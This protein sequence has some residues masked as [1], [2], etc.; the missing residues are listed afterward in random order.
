MTEQLFF[1]LIRVAIGTQERL[2]RLPSAC[3]WGELYKMARKQS[4]V[5]VCFAAIQRLGAD[6]DDGFASIGMSEML[7]LTWMGMAAKI[8]QKNEA[9]NQQCAELQAKLSADGLCSCVLKGQGVASLYS[10]YLRGF[11]QPGD[12]DVWIKDTPEQVIK[13]AQ[14]FRIDEEPSYLHI[15]V[16]M[17]DDTPVELHWRPTLFR[18][19]FN[20]R[21]IQRWSES[22]DANSFNHIETLGFDIPSDD[23]NRIFNLTHLYRHFMFEG[24]GLRQILDY[25]Y[26]LTK[27]D[28]SDT[29][30][31]RRFI[32]KLG[33]MRFAS[34]LMW[35]LKELF[36]LSEDRLL[37]PP[38][39]KEGKFLLYEIM[40]MGNFG[41]GDM[42]YRYDSVQVRMIKKWAH[43]LIHYPSEV[44]WNPIWI[45]CRKI[46]KY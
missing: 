15:G 36:G 3:E 9:L 22:F 25:Y 38:N 1:E 35:V 33:M 16:H 30:E 29:Y 12:I 41:H 18:N 39:Y 40:Q 31:E 4:L 32:R 13:Y 10:E 11:R 19:L 8:Q 34:A 46:K 24:V 17:F 28:C 44:I 6:A 37:F 27:S 7:Y 43:L 2:S 21:A 5:G 20:N 42:R 14:Q 26:V 45:L 23:F